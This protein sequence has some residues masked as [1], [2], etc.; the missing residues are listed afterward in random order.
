[1]GKGDIMFFCAILEATER[2]GF[3]R[4]IDSRKSIIELNVSPYYIKE[5]D[6][7]LKLI[8]KTVPFTILDVKD[9]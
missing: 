6:E 8:Q 5:M 9:E 7:L 1:M 4:T 3:V 2:F